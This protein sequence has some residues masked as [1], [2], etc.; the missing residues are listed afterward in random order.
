MK[1]HIKCIA[2]VVCIAL[3]LSALAGFS[4]SAQAEDAYAMVITRNA[5]IYT[6]KNLSGKSAK[7]PKYAIV[8]LSAESGSVSKIAYKGYTGYME[9]SAL[10]TI[11]SSSSIEAIFAVNGRVYELPST[12][13]R[14]AKITTGTRVNVLIAA[15]GCALIEKNGYLGYTRTKYLM[16]ANTEDGNSKDDQDSKDDQN[17][18]D[19]TG[20][21]DDTD[22]QDDSSGIIY[23]EFEAIVSDNSLKVYAKAKSSANVIGT[24]SKDTVV[25]VTAYTDTWARISFDG[26]VGCCLVSGLSKYVKADPTGDKIFADDSLSN[27]EKIFYFLLYEM[28]LNSAAACGILANIDCESGFRSTAVN[29]SSGA[30]GICQWLGGRKTNLQNYCAENDYDYT[31]LEGQLWYLKYELENRYPSVCAYMKSV[32]DSAQGTYDAG[33][34]WCYYFEI[35]GNRASTSVKRGNIARD[36]YWATYR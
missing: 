5:R 26:T 7:M 10:G 34:H 32:D 28:G 4:T 2:Q 18:K 35:P 15:N 36:D 33:Y 13:S 31:T 30:Y 11:D 8:S 21:K 23:E 27:E 25:T 19:D 24:L 22:E 12:A 17:S 16:A 20:T 14:S 1:L 3:L 29:S 9:S 6:N